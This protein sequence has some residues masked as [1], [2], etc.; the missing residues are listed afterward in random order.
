[1][2]KKHYKRRKLIA[3]GILLAL[4]IGLAGLAA[5]GTTETPAPAPAAPAEEPSEKPPEET[6]EQP[7]EKPS[8]AKEGVWP[9]QDALRSMDLSD[10]T[11]IRFTTYTEGGA[12]QGAVNDSASIEEICQML[13]GV[14]ITGLS[15]MAVDDD[16]LLVE[17]DAG[18]RKLTFRFEEKILVLEDGSRYEVEQLGALKQYLNGLLEE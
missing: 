9:A 6:T 13:G 14:R 11:E 17:V 1:M 12:Q 2:N 16:G 3:G 18:D 5:C 15:E 4:L 8:D 7:S 10:I